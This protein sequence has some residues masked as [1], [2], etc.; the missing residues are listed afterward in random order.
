MRPSPPKPPPLAAALALLALLCTGPLALADEP[1]PEEDPQNFWEAIYDPDRPAFSRLLNEAWS[2]TEEGRFEELEDRLSRLR[3]ARPEADGTL[4]FEAIVIERKGDFAGAAE[5]LTRIIDRGTFLDV[6]AA[7]VWFDL[8]YCHTRMGRYADAAEAYNRALAQEPDAQSPHITLSNLAE[9]HMALGQLDTAISHWREALSFDEGYLHALFGLAVAL[10]RQGHHDFARA[11]ALRGLTL[12]PELKTFLGSATFFV[13]AEDMS[14]TLGLL[15][16]EK[17]DWA[18]ARSH[19]ERFIA[20]ATA[21]S[22]L[23]VDAARAALAR[24]DERGSPLVG[25]G[26]LPLHRPTAVAADPAGRSIALGDELGRVTLVRL[27]SQ[28]IIASPTLSGAPVRA[29]AFSDAGR[30]LLAAR[31]DTHIDLIDLSRGARAQKALGPIALPSGNKVQALTLEGDVFLTSRN[32]KSRQW[33]VGNRAR[34]AEEIGQI[35]IAANAQDIALA[36]WD[37]ER[38]AFVAAFWTDQR[39][40]MVHHFPDTSGTRSFRPPD[41]TSEHAVA[42]TPDG[43]FAILVNARDILV[44]R[45]SDLQVVRM[46]KNHG[47]QQWG[48]PVKAVVDAAGGAGHGPALVILYAGHYAAYRLDALLPGSGGAP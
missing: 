19:Y 46:M 14:F 24:L 2:A 25:S 34:P 27:A 6:E 41:A 38:A 3:A 11:Y 23:Y 39:S 22:N 42:L 5:R 17:G 26:P 1:P 37:A 9:I 20:Q 32:A 31:D 21:S 44:C 7:A 28:S 10:E 33:G 4:F 35:N 36:A 12:D 8:A 18:L 29:L 15:A 43:R 13:P 47:E 16:E 48:A 40:L 45:T 30:H